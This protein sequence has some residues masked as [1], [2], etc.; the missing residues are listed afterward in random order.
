MVKLGNA[1]GK[2]IYSLQC[3]MIIIPPVAREIELPLATPLLG[4]LAN[5]QAS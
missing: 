3:V 5:K 2:D 1:P 4:I